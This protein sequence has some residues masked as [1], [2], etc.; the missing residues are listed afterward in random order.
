[1][2]LAAFSTRSYPVKTTYN[3]RVLHLFI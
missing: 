2:H 1:M 3:Q